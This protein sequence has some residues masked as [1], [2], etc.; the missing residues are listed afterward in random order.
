MVGFRRK[1]S[2]TV[3][4]AV[5]GCTAP[6]P[7]YVSRGTAVEIC[8]PNPC[9]PGGFVFDWDLGCEYETASDAGTSEAR[10]S[11]LK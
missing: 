8:P 5:V 10:E 3:G 9:E 6:N 2:F 4:F 1:L 7:D 11:D